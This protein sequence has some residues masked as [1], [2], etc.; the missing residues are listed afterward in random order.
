MLITERAKRILAAGVL[1]GVVIA[2]VILVPW[3]IPRCASTGLFSGWGIK[4]RIPMIRHFV[5]L[6]KEGARAEPQLI[7]ALQDDN[8][9]VPALVR[10]LSCVLPVVAV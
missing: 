4:T 10:R 6:Q 8:R 2:G 5:A 9:H 7:A 3:A 1:A